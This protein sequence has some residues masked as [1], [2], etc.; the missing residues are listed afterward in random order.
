MKMLIRNIKIV[1]VIF[2]VLSV[3]LLGGLVI[4]QLRSKT[5][6]FVAAGENKAALKTRYA[7]AGSIFDCDGAILAQ[8][9]DGDRVY[10]DNA[11][12]AKAVLHVVGDYTHN[13]DNTI[14]AR[15]QGQLLGTDRN[16]FHQFLLDFA[17]HG[18]EGDDVTLT[19]N[20]SLSKLAY[21]QLR[22][23]RG[24]IVLLNYQTGAILVSVSSPS[25]SP[26]SVIKFEDIPDTALFDRALLGAYAPGSTYK[27]LTTAAWL[28]SSKFDAK[29]A[30]D[31]QG[32]ST[33]NKNGAKES[34][35]GHGK[36]ELQSAFAESCNV[37]FGQIGAKMGRGSLLDIARQFGFGDEL[38]VDYL[39]ASTSRIE[40]SD[41]PAVLSWL[42]IGQPI[43][44][45]ILQV[46]PLQLAMIAGAV[47]NNGI[48][49]QPH[50]VDHLTDPLGIKY[51]Q[52]APETWKTVLDAKTAAKIEKLMI[53]VTQDGTGTSAAIS[54][55]TVA[56]KTGTVQVEGQ[57]NNALYVGY[58]T[59]DQCPYAIAVVIEGGG[60]GGRVAAPVA[61][62]LLREVVKLK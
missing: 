46:S 57:D 18:L 28:Q 48:M 11:I 14:E 50:L 36:T 43:E 37:F 12:T 25:T 10:S 7:N 40:T 8:S 35:N 45:S 13:I 21:Q 6:F 51:Q 47:G 23:R 9:Q 44:T 20:S 56:G 16:I 53:K 4:Q 17:G 26:S 27:I 60:S 38:Q 32:D 19:I 22:N 5:Q 62:R 29:L 30:V 58:I 2:L 42:S 39:S 33:V 49:Q 15:Y 24:A 54:G 52:M 3:S 61:A 34:G 59:D 31:C 41:D 1:L 55:Y